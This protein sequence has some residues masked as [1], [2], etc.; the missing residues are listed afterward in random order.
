MT[1]M[2]KEDF[3]V[4]DRV[5]LHGLSKAPHLNGRHGHIGY[6]M[7]LGTETMQMNSVL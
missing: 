5:V 1:E 6:V 7:L 4:G 3:K 2:Q